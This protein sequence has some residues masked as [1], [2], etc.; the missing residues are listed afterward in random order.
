MDVSY[1]SEFLPLLLFT[2]SNTFPYMVTLTRKCASERAASSVL[3]KQVTDQLRML[4]ENAE[5]ATS[6][7]GLQTISRFEIERRKSSTRG[8]YL[9]K[10]SG[11]ALP[12]DERKR[13]DQ[14]YE[15]KMKRLAASQ[16]RALQ[17]PA[18]MPVTPWQSNSPTSQSTDL[19]RPASMPVTP[20]QS[21]S[22]TP[23]IATHPFSAGNKRR[24]EDDGFEDFDV[25]QSKPVPKRGR[26][27]SSPLVSRSQDRSQ[28]VPDDSNREA[29]NTYDASGPVSRIDPYQ[30]QSGPN[31]SGLG[32]NFGE[33]DRL[34]PQDLTPPEQSQATPTEGN[35]STDHTQNAVFQIDYRFVDPQNPL[36]QLRIQAAL[37]YPRAHYYALVGEHPPHTSDGSYS[38]QYYQISALLAQNWMMAGGPPSLADVGP[39]LGGFDMVPSP[40]LPDEVIWAIL[41]PVTG[42]LP[43]Q[44]AVDVD[45]GSQRDREYTGSSDGSFE[46]LFTGTEDAEGDEK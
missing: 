33:E 4:G 29:P 44:T 38:D 21:A 1:F 5:R 16:P 18:S 8:K 35:A 25:G 13:R 40:D 14:K 37:F 34:N 42:S 10:A 28:T 7:K 31:A 45:T 26:L 12:K 43:V 46:D 27:G 17:R 30:G 22:P 23:Y 39:W 24:R 6:T 20:W 2:L 11:R 41:H 3:K 15:E 36:E 32:L 19:Q 9:Y